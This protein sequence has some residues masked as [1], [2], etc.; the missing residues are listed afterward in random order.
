MNKEEKINEEKK[1]ENKE[2]TKTENK[3]EKKVKSE[4]KKV[5]DLA[6][7]KGTSLRI[8]AKY[9]SE[10]CKVI[11]GKSPEKAIKRLNEALSKKRAIPMQRRET[12]HQ[13]GRGISGGKYPLNVCK[14]LIDLIKQASNNANFNGIENPIIAIAKADKASTPFRRG[15]RRAKRTHI[16]IEI[17]DKNKLV[18]KKWKKENSSK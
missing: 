15:G 4:V 8:S 13:K 2:N 6:F 3:E 12:P 16:Y 17:R 5:K 9:S 18:E 7:A 10:V 1:V 11:K 14:A